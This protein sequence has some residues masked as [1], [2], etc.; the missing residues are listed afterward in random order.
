[1]V[2]VALIRPGCTK[3]DEEGRI[4]GILDIPLSQQ[5]EEQSKQLSLELADF[6]SQS[7]LLPELSVIYSGP[8]QSARATAAMV[9]ENCA[10]KA[11]VLSCMTNVDHGL[12]Q[13]K[14][15]EEV[16]RLQPKLYRQIQE[17]A[18]SFAP[19]GGE[20]LDAAIE[21][22]RGSVAKLVKKHRKELIAIVV[23]DP[24]ASLVRNILCGNEIEDLWKLE[25]D[26][27]AW[28]IHHVESLP[29]SLV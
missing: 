18:D 11:K 12:W 27:A 14:L 10:V 2:H 8:C 7:K 5:G 3:F 29:A 21:R 16:K 9:A 17:S 20:T 25:K 1:M 15:V 28:E 19:P 24:L 22:V 4:K 13:G 26:G 23:P 6:L